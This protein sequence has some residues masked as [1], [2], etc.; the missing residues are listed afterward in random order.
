MSDWQFFA[1]FTVNL[2]QRG[3]ESEELAGIG[4]LNCNAVN[5][6]SK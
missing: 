4:K 5:A 2:F 6:E 3:A 1:A